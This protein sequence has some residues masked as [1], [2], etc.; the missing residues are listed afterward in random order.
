MPYFVD[1]T[2]LELC[3]STKTPFFVDKLGYL[4]PGSAFGNS[5]ATY[6]GGSFNIR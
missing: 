2:H 3:L 6:A 1:K 5:S 4:E